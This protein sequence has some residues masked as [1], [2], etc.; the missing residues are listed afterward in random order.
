[1][2]EICA[3]CG[4][5]KD[6]HTPFMESHGSD[7]PL[8]L[9]V[10]EAP[11][12][13][14]DSQGKP[15]VGKAGKLLRTVLEEVGFDVKRD[16]RFT[17][18][19]RCRPPMNK[20]TKKAI[21]YCSKFALEEIEQYNPNMVFLLGNSAL[22]GILG[23]T[24]ITNW[25]G[26][27]IDK[28]DRLYVPLYHP[29][30]L[31]RNPQPM[32]QWLSAMMT[33]FDRLVADPDKITA[34]SMRYSYPKTMDELFE[35]K[36]Y[37]DEFEFI[38]YD[39]EVRYLDAFNANNI[40]ISVSFAAGDVAY[41]VPIH[42]SEAPWKNID[43]VKEIIVDI[44]R[45]HNGN[46]IGHNIKFDQKHTY[47]TLGY[48]FDAGGDTML[49]S[50]LLDNRSGT[51]GLKRLA[52]VYIGMYEYDSVLVDYVREHKD[53]DP[54]RGGS[55]ENIP[56]S[57]LE[58]YSA[59]DAAA[60]LLLEEKLYPM[61]SDK[62]KEFYSG[63]FVSISNLL[64][65]IEM[66][67]FMI[68][69]YIADRYVRIYSSMRD[70]I[71]DEVISDPI[72]KKLIKSHVT[73]Q[74]AEDEFRISKKLHVKKSVPYR[75]N[76]G[77]PAAMVELVYVFGKTKVTYTTIK[78]APS[79]KSIYMKKYEG[80]MPVLAI[81]RYWKLL[82][83]MISTY[84]DPAVNGRWVSTIDGKVRCSYNMHATKTGR[85]SSTD[86]NLQNIPTPEKEPGTLL[87]YLPIKNVFTTSF[88]DGVVMSADQSGME[89]RVFA[90]L[91]KCTSMLEIH[92]S[93][94]DFHNMV[95]S[96]VSHIP[97]DS[98]P[99]HIRYK[100]KKVNWTLI[101]GGSAF[102]LSQLDGFPMDEAE[103]L[104]K[105][106]YDRFPE[107]P[108]YMEQCIEFSEDNNYIESPFGRRLHLYYIN[109]K[110]QIKLRNH[111]RRTC[112]NM[113]VQSGSSDLVLSGGVIISRKL[114][115]LGLRSRIVNT[116]HDSI[117]LDVPKSEIAMTAALVK[118]SMENVVNLAP[119]YFPIVDFSWMTC[120]LV[121]DIEIGSHYGAEEKYEVS[122][123]DLQKVRF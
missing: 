115:D 121:V 106:Y 79:T 110:Y 113:P 3:R 77:S 102:T 63:L 19:V 58:T 27:I 45:S 96:M 120:P 54:K 42:H 51:H 82:S 4:L 94:E 80:K 43:M 56:L 15:F 49:I 93:G 24:G 55:Y 64:G 105:S 117:I 88:E 62:Q 34:S 65:E 60:T 46:I 10:G 83:K 26:S 108:E 48:W 23:E 33:A 119:T 95:A 14:E 2:N 114:K 37:L 9:I 112:V 116:V 90:A 35:M 21:Q 39:T 28:N 5:H 111:D 76:P 29:A 61:L 103:E 73:A 68:D 30:Y 1:M 16:I 101:Y 71:Y 47:T 84:L 98:V 109:D 7:E 31:L 70:K 81:I 72:V 85:L 40:L 6:C 44:L 52:G 20:I 36:K 78:G 97:A 87:E 118:Y 32:D 75:F 53:A 11:G 99:K 91:S 59:M 100:F 89:L 66:N 69:G 50:Y 18:V 123:E 86:P 67:G 107:V 104:V 74:K 12:E 57:I 38:A 22:S 41:S 122:K 25:N 17:N 92:K 13:D 8:V